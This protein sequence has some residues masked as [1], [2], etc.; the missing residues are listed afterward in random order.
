MGTGY[1]FVPEV[2]SSETGLF[3][4]YLSQHIGTIK[5]YQNLEARAEILGQ[6]DEQFLITKP[7]A[8]ALLSDTNITGTKIRPTEIDDFGNY[9]TFG[10]QGNSRTNPPEATIRR[11]SLWEDYTDD[12]ATIRAHV[13]GVGTISPVNTT[14]GFLA[15]TWRDILPNGIEPDL[16]V[17]ALVQNLTEHLNLEQS[18]ELHTTKL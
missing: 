4:S 7:F 10:G 6:Q 3:S 9:I 13:D 17:W 14:H 12:N 8:K 11:S 1:N 15:T 16:I 18:T 5:D 2:N